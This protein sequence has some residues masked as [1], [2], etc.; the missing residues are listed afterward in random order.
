MKPINMK[1]DL[2]RVTIN[3]N[4]VTE[5]NYFAT[6]RQVGP[7]YLS[8]QF[9][10]ENYYKRDESKLI[11]FDDPRSYYTRTRSNP[12]GYKRTVNIQQSLEEHKIEEN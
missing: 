11:T 8:N 2:S 1:I 4:S 12:R 10:I 7:N 6:S 3:D 5:I 9:S